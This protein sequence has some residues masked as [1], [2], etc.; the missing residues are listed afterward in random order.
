MREEKAVKTT[1]ALRQ[2]GEGGKGEGKQSKFGCGIQCG[3][4]DA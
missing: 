3:R 2:T 1:T 4:Q